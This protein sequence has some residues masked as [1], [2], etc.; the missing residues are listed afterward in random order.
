MTEGL[1]K[2]VQIVKSEKTTYEALVH[3][4]SLNTL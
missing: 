1:P 2:E 4:F 3:D